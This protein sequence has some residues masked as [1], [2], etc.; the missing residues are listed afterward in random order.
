MLAEDGAAGLIL[1]GEGV[2]AFLSF[3]EETHLNFTFF[4]LFVAPTHATESSLTSFVVG[5]CSS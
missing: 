5:N 3:D 2:A 4:P 1:N